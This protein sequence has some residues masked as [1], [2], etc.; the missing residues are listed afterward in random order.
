[1]LCNSVGPKL[2]DKLRIDPSRSCTD[3]ESDINKS[4]I[5]LPFLAM[6]IAVP[7]SKTDG[8]KSENSVYTIAYLSD[9]ANP[10]PSRFS[11]RDYG[12]FGSYFEATVVPE[13]PLNLHY[14]YWV[15]DGASK[16][17]TIQNLSDQFANPVKV[18]VVK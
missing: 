1:M 3:D 2:E 7:N 11:E 10:K 4:H 12:R 17:N 14:R 16:T 8:Q 9:D 18:E 13:A 15:V 5:N 6:T